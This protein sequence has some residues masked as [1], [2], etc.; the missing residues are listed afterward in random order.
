MISTHDRDEDS[1]ILGNYFMRDYYLIFDQASSQ[2]GFAQKRSQ[3]CLPSTSQEPLTPYIPS[4]FDRNP[5]TQ[6]V[7]HLISLAVAAYLS[8]RALT[9]CMQFYDVTFAD[10]L[11][12]C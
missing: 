10:L 2:L 3:Y 12:A 5:I 4:S 9:G 1:I 7:S 6:L 8:Y 11:L